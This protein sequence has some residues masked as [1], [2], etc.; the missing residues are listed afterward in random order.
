[1]LSVEYARLFLYEFK[2]GRGE[3]ETEEQYQFGIWRQNWLEKEKMAVSII[4]FQ[5]GKYSKFVVSIV[6]ISRCLGCDWKSDKS[7]LAQFSLAVTPV[8][9]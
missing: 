8:T 5:R 1:M 6:S 3:A 9:A 7:K 2:L 4:S